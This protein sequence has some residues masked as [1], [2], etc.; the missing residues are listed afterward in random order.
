MI[1]IVHIAKPI[2]GVGVYIQ[3][4]SKY[5]N[6]NKYLNIIVCNEKDNN[7]ELKNSVGEELEKYHIN[8]Q[9]EISIINDIK[10]LIKLIRVLKRIKP[11][12]IHCHSAKAGILGRLAGIYLKIPVLYTPHA[13]SY[14]STESKL[15][16][17]FYKFVEKLFRLTPAKTLACSQSEY[18][19]AIKDLKFQKNKVLLWNNSVEETTIKTKS[20]LPEKLPSQFICTIGR[21]SYQKNTELLIN[22]IHMA[23]KSI[24]NIHLVILGVGLYSPS[25]EYIKNQIKKLDLDSNITLV[26]WLPREE[27]LSILQKSLFYISSSRYEGLPYA[28][29][30]ALMLSKACVLTNIDGNK[31]LVEDTKNGFLVGENEVELATAI[32]RL[33]YNTEL[34]DKM[35]VA[36]KQ[37]F[38]LEFDIK[39]NIQVLEKI[40]TKEVN[41]EK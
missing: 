14:L 41:I 16:A 34:L 23:K 15:K 30:E 1:K 32:V 17:I 21:P 38:I 25:L 5:L 13:F 2:G 9:R 37:K 27:S 35:S 19:R 18:K 36:S 11:N 22:A 12:L 4:L 6:A 26:E 28:A 31:D 29:I 10:V 33:Y 39:N 20:K 8:I 40:Y 24:K 7:I 3:L